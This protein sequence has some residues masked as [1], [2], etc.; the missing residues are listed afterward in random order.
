M[1]Y[2]TQSYLGCKRAMTYYDTNEQD[3]FTFLSTIGIMYCD[4]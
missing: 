3:D 1:Y 4:I 2:G